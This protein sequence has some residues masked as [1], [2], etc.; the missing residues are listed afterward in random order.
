M[1]TKPPTHDPLHGLHL[2]LHT[3]EDLRANSNDRGY[4]RGHQRRRAI[5]LAEHPLCAMCLAEGRVTAAT[6]YD[7]IVPINA[8]GSAAAMSNGQGLCAVCH[9][10]KTAKEDGGFG[11]RRE[12]T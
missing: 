10:R 9:S 7:H 4:G 5:V 8:G 6:V 11:N 3:S 1:P 2:R 12:G